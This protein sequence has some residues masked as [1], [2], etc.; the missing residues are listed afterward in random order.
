MISFL[1]PIY[2][3]KC[4]TLD[5][6]GDTSKYRWRVATLWF[7][8]NPVIWTNKHLDD[9]GERVILDSLRKVR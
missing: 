6:N 1:R 2:E 3:L 8:E 7:W 9:L 5:E 4:R